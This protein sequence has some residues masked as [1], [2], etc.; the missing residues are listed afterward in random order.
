M[1]M[2][3]IDV[4]DHPAQIEAGKEVVVFGSELSVVKVAQWAATIPY[5]ILTGI[6]PRVQRVYFEQ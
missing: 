1:D 3:M 5:E 2:T 6:S 4:T